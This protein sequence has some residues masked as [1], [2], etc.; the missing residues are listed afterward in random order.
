MQHLLHRSLNDRTKK[1][2]YFLDIKEI[3]VAGDLAIVRLVWTLKRNFFWYVE[4][5]GM[6]ESLG[7]TCS[8]GSRMAVGG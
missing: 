2:T 1:F 7:S 5:G 4:D 3:I 6:A 8:A